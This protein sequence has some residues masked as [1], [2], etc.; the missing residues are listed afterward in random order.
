MQHF[1]LLQLLIGFESGTVVLW[2]LKSKKADYRYT[3]D[4]VITSF[5]S[6]LQSRMA[7]LRTSSINDFRQPLQLTVTHKFLH[8]YHVIYSRSSKDT[9]TIS[10]GPVIWPSNSLTSSQCQF[11]MYSSRGIFCIYKQIN[12]CV[13]AF[14]FIQM[15]VYWKYLQLPCF[16]IQIK[17]VIN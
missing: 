7:S 4:E 2:D 12:K 13:L 5:L 11:L 15:I 16:R 8:M 9:K 3:Y 17:I 1:L 10:P 6:F 14:Y